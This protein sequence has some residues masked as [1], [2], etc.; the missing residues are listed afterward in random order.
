MGSTPAGRSLSEN[1]PHPLINV[2]A[3]SEGDLIEMERWLSVNG[4][5][6]DV[7]AIREFIALVRQEAQPRPLAITIVNAKDIGGPC[8]RSGEIRVLDPS[9]NV[10]RVI[11]STTRIASF[12][13]RDFTA[14]CRDPDP[15][16]E[17]SK[18]T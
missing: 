11:R 9:G 12:W 8:F 4:T 7:V 18:A 15:V 2:E 16:G 3:A 1:L 6:A 13:C 10:E 17:V 5:G 14:T